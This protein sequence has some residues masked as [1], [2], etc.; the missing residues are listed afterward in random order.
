MLSI[1]GAEQWGKIMS[2]TVRKLILLFL[3]VALGGCQTLQERR[4][5]KTMDATL[6]QYEGTMRWGHL[7]QIYD[8][9]QPELAKNAVIPNNLGDIR[10]TGYDLLRS[11]TSVDE[12]SIMQTVVIR[13]VHEDRQVEK[14]LVDRQL[15]EFDPES[16]KWSR[17]NPIP[18]FD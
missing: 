7:Q 3:V 8:F 6:R 17:A 18:G 14:Q 15:W 12:H 4:M 2:G 13:Y 11:P 9:L 10:V 5:Q 1:P 16:E